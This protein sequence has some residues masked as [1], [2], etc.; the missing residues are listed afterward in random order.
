MRY[1]SYPRQ[2][3]LKQSIKPISTYWVV[4][5]KLIKLNHPKLLPMSKLSYCIQQAEEQGAILEANRE[6]TYKEIIIQEQRAKL[7]HKLK[8]EQEEQ[9]ALEAFLAEEKRCLDILTRHRILYDLHLMNRHQAKNI[10]G[11][12]TRTVSNSEAMKCIGFI[13]GKGI[14]TGEKLSFHEIMTMTDEEL[15]EHTRPVLLFE[16]RTLLDSLAKKLNCITIYGEN[17]FDI[18]FEDIGMKFK[19]GDFAKK[20]FGIT[21][22]MNKAY[23]DFYKS[24][25]IE[26]TVDTIKY[27]QGQ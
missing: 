17:M 8:K 5:S 16:V 13:H 23:H 12:L 4:E 18:V 9:K 27:F 2:P 1:T 7:E 22:F 26:W 6:L 11:S 25:N 15:E 3:S 24:A 20:N 14:H 21:Y 19:Y 10:V